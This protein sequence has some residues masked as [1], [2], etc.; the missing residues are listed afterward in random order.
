MSIDLANIRMLT[1]VA[2]ALAYECGMTED[3]PTAMIL[4]A[5]ALTMNAAVVRLATMP[6][7]YTVDPLPERIKAK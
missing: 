2:D 7:G 5:L 3:K 6:L 4:A 1:A